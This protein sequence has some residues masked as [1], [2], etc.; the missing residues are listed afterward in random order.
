MP[1]GC[2]PLVVPE[3]RH[4]TVG[5]AIVGI[6]IESSSFKHGLFHEGMME[7]DVLLPHGK[8]ELVS[9]DTFPDLFDALPNSL[10]CFGYLVRVRMR[11]QR[12]KPFVRIV[13]E[14]F[15]S[16]DALVDGLIASCNDKEDFVDAVA[17]SDTGGVVV[18]ATFAES[19]PVG[20]DICPDPCS[21]TRQFYCTLLTDG[22][23]Y[24]PTRDYIWRWDA[25]WFWVAQIF[26]GSGH[27]LLRWLCGHKFL[28][29]DVYKA[30]NDRVKPVL[31]GLFGVPPMEHVVQDII[32]PTDTI[33]QFITQH[34][35]TTGAEDF[36][37]VKLSRPGSRRTVPLWLCPVK[38]TT[39]TLFP[40]RPNELYI[41]I[42]FWDAIEGPA[43]T[44]GDKAG[45]VNRK[46]E[47][48]TAELGALKTL[49]S[50]SYYEEADLTRIYG[51]TSILRE[52]YDPQGRVRPM[53]ARLAKP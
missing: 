41:N 37:K 2:L 18:T 38:G 12:C 33:K 43:T 39:A 16:R 28:R 25:D 32:V 48:L 51:D 4:I 14:N 15:F 19:V 49:Y 50:T 3:L 34:I 46:L 27:P 40:Q 11:V 52:K 35:K 23:Y 1:Y 17:L 53:Y 36:G 30:F 6:G 9:K 21:P 8:V 5:G 45:V 20:A 13:R 31:D 47:A 7:A 22:I 10:G 26:P 24:M 44:G 29:S 42:G